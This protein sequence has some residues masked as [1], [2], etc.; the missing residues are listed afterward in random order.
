MALKESQVPFALAGSYGLWARGGP[1]PAHDVDFMIA[2]DDATAVYELL[3][4][5]GL[6]VV[7]PPEDWLFKTYVDGAMVDV[8][9]RAGARSIDRGLFGEADLLEVESVQMPVLSA[10]VLMAHK[11]GAMDERACDFGAVLPAARA[12]REQVDWE[13]VSR[14][15]AQ[16]PFARSFLGLLHDLAIA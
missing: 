12:V 13:E 4:G 6:E 1:E 15:T 5:R 10:T 2:E 11:L 8:I 9:H 16:N 14:R 3:A 7:Q